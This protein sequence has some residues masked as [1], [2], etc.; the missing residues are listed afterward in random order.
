[1]LITGKRRS[2]KSCLAYHIL[3]KF[4]I[5]WKIP[6]FVVSLPKEKH[7]LLPSFIK[8]VDTVEELPESCIALV[9]EGSLKYHAHLWQQ[10]ETVVMDRMLS[11]SG[12]KK[13]T[14]IFISH[15][16]RKFAVT[17]LLEI[18]LLLCKEPSLLHSKL[19][20]SEVR[21]ITEEVTREFKKL[22]KDDV[23]KSVYVISEEFVGFI[24]NPKPSWWTEEL[25]EAYAGININGK[26][27]EKKE[28]EIVL[29]TRIE[30]G[31]KLWFKEEEK[32]KVLHILS[33]NSTIDGE[34]HSLGVQCSADKCFYSF[35]LT[36][37][38]G[39]YILSDKWDLERSLAEF[40]EK[41]ISVV[42]DVETAFPLNIED[43]VFKQIKTKKEKKDKLKEYAE[44]IKL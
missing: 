39:K 33:E 17:L 18:D 32:V 23:K 41:D 21:K 30:E 9:D 25:S 38:N 7:Q 11:V 14:F 16:M 26:K 2:G 12:Q 36:L 31:L 29:P 13:Q 20:R 19:E 6:C 22:P 1:M 44:K 37:F 40:K 28:E 42:V 4:S 10:K 27:E 15:T 8:P 24:R 5:E 43:V 34:L 35:D 3:E